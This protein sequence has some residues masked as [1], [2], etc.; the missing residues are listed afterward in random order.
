[1]RRTV[2][3]SG[4]RTHADSGA[5]PDRRRSAPLRRCSLRSDSARTSGLGGSAERPPAWIVLR[6]RGNLTSAGRLSTSFT[7]KEPLT[8]SD[9]ICYHSSLGGK[10]A[11]SSQRPTMLMEKSSRRTCLRRDQWSP[12][13]RCQRSARRRA[14][15]SRRCSMVWQLRSSRSASSGSTVGSMTRS[16]AGSL[17][18]RV[19]TRD[20]RHSSL[21]SIS[22]DVAALMISR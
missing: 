19:R 10:L 9:K 3:P 5:L 7:A 13:P 1:M 6:P 11:C 18:A 22:S 20:D 15:I 8:A 4:S 14:V 21:R 2:L 16:N 17:D 12:A